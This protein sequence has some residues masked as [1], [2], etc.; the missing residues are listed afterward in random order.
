LLRG[1]DWPGLCTEGRHQSPVDIPT[2]TASSSKNVNALKFNNNIN[3]D[4]NYFSEPTP[5]SIVDSGVAIE[6]SLAG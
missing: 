6:S 3:F 1:D 4:T 2:N 5:V